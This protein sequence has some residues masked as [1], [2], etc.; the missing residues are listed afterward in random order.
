MYIEVINFCGSQPCSPSRE[1]RYYGLIELKPRTPDR[2]LNNILQWTSWVGYFPLI[3]LLRLPT[4]YLILKLP[5]SKM[6]EE[7]HTSQEIIDQPKADDDKQSEDIPDFSKRKSNRFAFDL[8]SDYPGRQ[9]SDKAMKK[10]D[11]QHR[12]LELKHQW[13][14]LRADDDSNS[15][16]STL[17]EF[18]GERRKKSKAVYE[19]SPIKPKR[20]PAKV[21]TVGSCG[22]STT[23]QRP[24]PMGGATNKLSLHC[25]RVWL[26]GLWK[27]S[28]RFHASISRTLKFPGE[29]SPTFSDLLE[30][31]KP[32]M[33]Q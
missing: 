22:W 25:Q 16:D 5:C 20:F 12:M 6:E 23:S 31:L 32:K 19:K 3:Y 21:S 4:N 1:P 7:D 9:T 30:V 33:Q 29:S 26:I 27:N 2:K 24:K 10:L 14:L 18:A 11:L 8:D 17:T 28:K 15:D 13:K